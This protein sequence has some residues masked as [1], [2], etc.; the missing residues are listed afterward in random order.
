MPAMTKQQ[1]EVLKQLFKAIENR[2]LNELGKSL[3]ARVVYGCIDIEDER[4]HYAA[5]LFARS[6][7]RFTGSVHLVSDPQSGT[8]GEPSPAVMLDTGPKESS[9]QVSVS[10]LWVQVQNE[11]LSVPDRLEGV[12]KLLGADRE[13]VTNYVAAE[14]AREGAHEDW[15]FALVFLAEDI[16]F[17]ADQQQFAK[18]ALLRIAHSF[19]KSTKAG[20][21]RIVWSAIRRASSLLAPAQVGLLVPFLERGGVVDARAVTLKCI[22]KMF[23]TAPPADP[24]SVQQIGERAH[25]LANKFL[26]P[27]IFGGGEDALLAQSA[28]CALAAIGDTRFGDALTMAAKLNRRWLKHQLRTRLDSLR[29]SWRSKGMDAATSDAFRNLET[30]LSKLG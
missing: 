6:G 9:E 24:E 29:D 28:V 23:L 13:K 20:A 10:G 21:E 8:I 18:D 5:T 22:E 14:L 27:D 12:F 1:E 15:I 19:R 26:D 17:P 2:C 3:T 16:H 25:T 4:E 11:S 7:D 30:G